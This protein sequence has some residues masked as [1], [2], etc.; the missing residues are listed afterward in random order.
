[1]TG[2][3]DLHAY[4]AA[5][6]RAPRRAWFVPG[7]IEVL[8]KHTDYAG[9]RS[10]LCAIDRGFRIVAAP[11]DDRIVTM[12]D[13]A[14]DVEAT[15]EMDASLPQA[16]GRWSAYPRVVIRRLARH[17]PD[18]CRGA[19]IAFASDL[20]PAAGISSS[21]AFLIATYLALAA[22]NDIER[23]ATFRDA[24]RSREDLADFLAAIESGYGFG[25]FPGDHGVGISGGSQDHTAILCCR[26]DRLS[27]YSFNPACH[28][29]DI[30]LDPD[31][32][33]VIA[34]S[35]IT[36]EKAGAAREGY[37][38]ASLAASRILRLWNE[39]TGRADRSLAA[40]ATSAP[41][42]AERI[43]ALAAGDG[44]PYLPGRF[45]QFFA[46]S[47]EIIPAA[48]DALARRDYAAFGAEVDRSQD[49]VE[50]LLGNQIQQTIDLPR[51]ARSAGA[52][53]ASAFGGGFGGSVWALVR[54]ADAEAFIERW[55]A[56]YR[57][58]HPEFST[59]AT[60]FATTAGDGAREVR[61]AEGC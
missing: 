60:F 27:V 42:A 52:L 53:A 12:S 25:P 59:A 10:L 34:T 28:E 16:Q 37:N 22:V 35:G 24:I 32:R 2:F 57:R 23:D 5:R 31:V 54:A 46:E 50:R 4:L 15:L 56:D 21:T 3:D 26:R 29:R 48:A 39:A 40:A 55:A 41:G 14:H 9:G 11:R 30:D 19:D 18:A 49:L 51:S 38:R 13:L 58:L 17:F 61:G 7:R 36:A 45:D 6:N 20:P 8:G 43:R 47:L 44:D 33:F 1:M